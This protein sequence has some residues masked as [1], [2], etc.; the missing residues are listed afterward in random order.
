MINRSDRRRRRRRSE[1][2]LGVQSIDYRTEPI[3][4]RISLDPLLKIWQ[5]YGV[6]LS[7][8]VLL[9]GLLW[10]AYTL[11]TSTRFFIYTAEIQGN[12]AVSAQEI[13]KTSGLDS[14]SI[15]WV[16]PLEVTNKISALPNIKSVTVSV[17]LPA[18]VAIEVV[19][20][21][22]ELLWQTGE[23]VW[24]VDQEGTIV[25]P[26][27][28]LTGMLRIVD[29]ENQPLQP[30]SQIDATIVEGAQT[31]QLLAPDVSVVR[32]SREKGLIA[33]TP[34]GWPV[35]LGDGGEI[36]AKLVVLTELL[37]DL[38]E[39]NIT[40]AYIDMRDPMRPVYRPHNIIRINEPVIG[41][42]V[43]PPPP[44]PVIP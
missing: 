24:W 18:Q 9:L 20:R 22:P 27:Q 4:P 40:P 12:I 1:L 30:G 33:A 36:K 6:K 29:D 42:R 17:T 8:V 19:E 11:F 31:L 16:D 35:Y 21:R 2:R 28:D 37:V 26:K 25:P 14:Q 39:R 38:K 43:V 32:Y 13:Y 44:G 10:S 7:G 3:H 15:F 41:Q 23:T 34:E 5:Q